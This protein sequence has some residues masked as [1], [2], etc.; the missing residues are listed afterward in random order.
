MGTGPRRLLIDTGDG[1]DSWLKALQKTLK[2]ENAT[3]S[4]TIL[5]HWHGDHVGGI[6]QV[7][8]IIPDVKFHKYKREDDDPTVKEDIQHELVDGQLLSVEGARL[9][10]VY[11]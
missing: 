5:T 11:S 9:K 2:E 10:T 8:S 3:I 4:D 1:Q 6:K 7:K